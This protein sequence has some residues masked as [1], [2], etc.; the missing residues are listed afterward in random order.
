MT[1]PLTIR[2]KAVL[3]FIRSYIDRKGY[4]PTYAEISGSLAIRSR[5]DVWRIIEGLEKR[6]AVRVLKYRARGI[7]LI[8]PGL[9]LLLHPEVEERLRAFAS[10]HGIAPE[11]AA[12]EAIRHYVGVA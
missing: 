5:S 11:T 7:T 10:R 2:Q 4:S 9:H 3:D 12:A 6:G 8:E 1:V